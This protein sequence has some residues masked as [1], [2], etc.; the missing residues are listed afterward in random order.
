M[1]IT[2]KSPEEENAKNFLDNILPIMVDSNERSLNIGLSKRFFLFKMMNKTIN[3]IEDNNFLNFVSLLKNYKI[4]GRF[5]YDTIDHFYND[6]N[7]LYF[8]KFFLDLEMYMMVKNDIEEI[9]PHYKGIKMTIT[10]RGIIIYDNYKPNSFNTLLFTIHGGTWVDKHVEKKIMI[11]RQLRYTEEDIATDKIYRKLV[12]EKGGIWI[13][14]KQSRF[15]CDL[16]RSAD[17]AIY[18]ENSE[19]WLN[20]IW[21]EPLSQP[22]IKEIRKFYVEFYFT[23]SK[24]IETYNFN[25]IFDGH[26]MKNL[27]G[28]PM[29]S[30]GT[31]HIP[32]FYLPIVRS[33][34]RKLISL[35]YE[36]VKLNNPFKGGHIL[37]WLSKRYPNVFIFSMEVNKKLYMNKKADRIFKSRLNKLVDDLV[38]IFDIEVEDEFK[39][40]NSDAKP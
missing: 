21:Q 4:L 15:V 13:D 34:Q 35:G 30:F 3:L 33:M 26:S 2:I 23:L 8:K 40:H 6:R 10:K 11:D 20:K 25:I 12:L 28:R 24:I 9:Y 31:K 32:S 14:N 22:E 1:K 18:K 5:L 39:E 7:K 38:K 37:R 29:L 16:N 36:S 27:S 19:A 17:T